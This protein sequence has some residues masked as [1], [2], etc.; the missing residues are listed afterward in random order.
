MAD[1][2]GLKIGLEGEKEFKKSLSEIN[3]SFKVLGSEMKLVESQFDKNDDS[4]E[5]LSSRNAVLNKEIEAQKDKINTLKSALENAATSFGETDRRTQNWQIQLNN[6]EAALNKM[7]KEV[8]SNN[9]KLDEADKEFENAERSADDFGD[10]VEDSG[11]QS[12]DASNKFDKLGSVCKGAA[13]ALTGAIVAVSAAAVECGKALINMSLSGAEYADNVLTE[14]QVTGIATDKL[15]EYMYA[16]ELVDVSTETLTKSMAKNIKSMNT[17]S[18]GTGAAAEAYKKLGV[19]VTNADGS[20]RDS[21]T[22]YWEL[23]DSL[24]KVQNETE[25]DALAMQLLGKSAQ[26]LNP[27][28]KQGSERM[29]ELGEKAH[30]AGYVV[31]EE[32]LNA[33]GELDDQ[34]QYLKVGVEGAKNSLG[35]V[36]LPILTDLATTGNE[37]LGEF[38][39]GMQDANGDIGKMGEVI[40]QVLPKALDAINK[41]IPDIINLITTVLGVIGKTIMDNLPAIMEMISG[42]VMQILDALIEMLPDIIEGVMTLFS[43]LLEGLLER[44]PDIVEALIEGL[45]TLLESLAEM[46]P[47]LIP[48]IVE[49]IMGI[50]NAIIEN[51]DVFIDALMQFVEGLVEG[52]VNALPIF[53]EG[54]MNLVLKIVE[55]L[56]DILLS[57]IDT[58]VKMIPVLIDGVL[59]CLPQLIQ[60][61]ITLVISLVEHLPEII[62]A[63]VESAPYIIKSLVEGIIQALPILINGAVTLVVELVKHMPQIIA[64]LI[65]AIPGIVKSIASGFGSLV[66][67]FA[68]IGLNMIKG[69][70]NGISNAAN[71]IWEKISGFFGGIVD[72]IKN[73]F[74]IHSPSTLFRDKIGKNLALGL[75]EGFSDEMN[76]V[77]NQME[78]AIPSDFDTQ[79]NATVNTG[80]SKNGLLNPNS[81]APVFNNNISFGNVTIANDMDIQD[82]AAKVS[83]YIVSDVM[84]KGGAYA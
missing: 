9:E 1:N 80:I 78:K 12:A 16:A 52:I 50:I 17:A 43:S 13:A 33:Y 22:V 34:V 31:S 30:E 10:E 7:E 61:A 2:F 68:E 63:I 6:A 42:I 55:K 64:G 27:L 59:K 65:K 74:G 36:F 41:Y 76:K 29:Q 84:K 32:M 58:V 79:V 23:I 37:L 45:S 70:W 8:K 25:R 38:S 40:E 49:A 53:I 67:K 60:G 35:T 15:Q 72:G 51:I 62:M 47:T 71:W 26:E 18:S 19:Q 28:I 39:K 44:L 11:K 24:G 20:L 14:S 57:I 69:I 54:I 3:Q 48:M 4:I 81:N 46:L 75:G 83:D 66:G 5:A 56:P 73:F 82:V 77:S 21:D